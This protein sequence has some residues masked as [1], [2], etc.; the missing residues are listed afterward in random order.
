[1]APHALSL[2]S[3]ELDVLRVGSEEVQASAVSNVPN[4]SGLLGR[5]G[6][7][8]PAGCSGG[9]WGGGEAGG[10]E[11]ASGEAGVVGAV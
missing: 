2:L 5:V 11:S 9:G 6:V 4:P 3:S 8:S 1:M 7:V 10:S